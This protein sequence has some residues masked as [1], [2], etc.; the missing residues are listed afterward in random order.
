MTEGIGAIKAGKVSRAYPRSGIAAISNRLEKEQ[1]TQQ[2]FIS[3]LYIREE[4]PVRGGLERGPFQKI[5]FFMPPF[6]CIYRF[7]VESSVE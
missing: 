6:P 1:L 7:R 2:P 5:H 4:C 3:A